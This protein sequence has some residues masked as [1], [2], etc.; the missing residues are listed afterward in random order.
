MEWDLHNRVFALR[1]VGTTIP[2]IMRLFVFSLVCA[3]YFIIPNARPDFTRFNCHDSE[4]YLALAHSVV[5]GRGYTRSMDPDHYVGHTLWPPGMPIL[6]M[7]AIAASGATVNWFA[8]KST[9]IVVGLIGVIVVW[10]YVRRVTAKPGAADLGAFVLAVNPFYW[11]F[12]HQAMAEMPVVVFAV[13]GLLLCDIVFANRTPARSA[14]GGVGFVCGLGML[15]KGTLCGLL[16]VPLAYL[17]GTRKMAGEARQKLT[18]ICLFAVCFLVPFLGWSLRNATVDAPG[19]DGVNQVRMI[20]QRD[21]TDPTLKSPDESV[22]QATWNIRHAAIYEI[23]RQI[24]PGFWHRAAFS[25]A[26][27]GIL[28]LVLSV[29]VC[30]A[31]VPQRTYLLPLVVAVAPMVVLYLPYALGGAARY[32]VP[33]TI[34]LQ[35]ILVINL[36]NT[37]SRHTASLRAVAVVLPVVLLVN[38]SVYVAAHEKTPYNPDGDW[39]DLAALFQKVNETELNSQRVLTPNQHAFQL[40]TG[41]RTQ[42]PGAPVDHIVARV[43]GYGYPIPHGAVVVVKSG[44]LAL[45]R[46]SEPMTPSSITGRTDLTRAVLHGKRN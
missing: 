1:H 21:V 41:I 27:S 31:A 16:L 15:I 28:A 43:D 32:W 42:R 46:L 24:I 33:V 39:K 23:P 9:M 22:Q 34:L 30:A 38:I 35:L 6:L 17:V 40:M 3:L 19:F 26:G 12:S 44:N 5:H 36:Y 29:M 7:P 8:V 2:R 11:D 13:L 18:A 45:F 4:S 20:L 10:L 25:W 37:L 14:V